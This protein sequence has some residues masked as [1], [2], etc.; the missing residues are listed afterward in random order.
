MFGDR[1]C[2][3]FDEQERPLPAGVGSG[4]VSRLFQKA[5][6]CV[7]EGT[8]HAAHNHGCKRKAFFVSP[9]ALVSCGTLVED[10][11]RYPDSLGCQGGEPIDTWSFFRNTGLST[12]TSDG[13]G[14][15]TPYTS[16]QCSGKDPKGNGC[17]TCAGVVDQCVDSGLPPKFYKVSTF[18]RI[19]DD[20]L[21]SRNRTDR[22][23][24]AKDMPALGRQIEAMQREIMTNGPIH[25]CVDIFSNFQDTFNEAPLTIYNKTKPPMTGGHCLNIIGWGHDTET[26]VDYWII[27]NS[28]GEAWGSLGTFRYIRG[29]DLG[30][31][32]SD[33]W[34]GCP[35]GSNCKLTSAVKL[36]ENDFALA[37]A[38]D[39]VESRRWKGGY[40]RELSRPEF[41]Q[42]R[43]IKLRIARAYESVFGEPTTLE[44]AASTVKRMFTQAGVRGMRIR[45]EFFTE[46]ADTHHESISHYHPSGV[47]EIVQTQLNVLKEA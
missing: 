45:V 23:R 2:I 5:G 14:G 42:S 33:V 30:G 10:P 9:Q 31:I 43:E 8:T 16:G 6:S 32:E 11:K 15:C 29:A 39:S 7:G 34:A 38:R 47:Q 3:W 22:A 24:P 19:H 25:V 40:W 27:K 1:L 20:G 4:G 41:M 35:A 13:K 12:M 26:N 46:N 37:S 36:I 18:G 21:P 44:I 28:W 17:R